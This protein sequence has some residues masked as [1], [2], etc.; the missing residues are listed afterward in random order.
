MKKCKKDVKVFLLKTEQH[1]T[2]PKN[3][4]KPT[5][6]KSH[7]HYLI[8]FLSSVIPSITI[9]RLTFD[10]M[11]T[12]PQ[13]FSNNY[14]WFPVLLK[15]QCYSALD[16]SGISSS[17]RWHTQALVFYTHWEGESHNYS[18]YQATWSWWL[19]IWS[20]NFNNIFRN[21]H[22]NLWISHISQRSLLL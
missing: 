18:A 1:E 14:F 5:K 11:S 9:V 2:I 22:W 6:K 10:H 17:V 15:G 21:A 7:F 20:L 4:T 8:V 12:L 3:P 16:H 19:L 13:F